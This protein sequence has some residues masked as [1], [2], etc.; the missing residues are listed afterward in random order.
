MIENACRFV[1]AE[2][3][4]GRAGSFVD[5]IERGGLAAGV[6]IVTGEIIGTAYDLQM[7]PYTVHPDTGAAICG[8]KLPN[9]QQLLR[10]TE[11]CARACP[12]AF[13]EWDI[14]IRENDCVL[15]EA[16]ANARNT[17]IQMGEFHGR[18]KQFEELEELYI[19]SVT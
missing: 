18:K 6:D 15:I 12:L 3:R 16:N 9:W 13:V 14:A 17:E 1:A 2:F 7:N 19:R 8:L 11:E 4:M 5:N 10:F